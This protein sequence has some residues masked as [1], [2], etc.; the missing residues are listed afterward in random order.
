MRAADDVQADRYFP[1][2]LER[3]EA[4]RRFV[5]QIIT[6]GGYHHREPNRRT[7]RQRGYHHRRKVRLRCRLEA[8]EYLRYLY[9]LYA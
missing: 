4:T 6:S 3:D 7:E 1:N 2:S 9:E 5:A 8:K